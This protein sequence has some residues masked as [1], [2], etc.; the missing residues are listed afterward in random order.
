MLNSRLW[1]AAAILDTAGLSAV[2]TTV[3]W[4]TG[5]DMN[6]LTFKKDLSGSYVKNSPVKGLEWKLGDQL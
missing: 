2:G 6:F 1:L 3:G 5:R 4:T